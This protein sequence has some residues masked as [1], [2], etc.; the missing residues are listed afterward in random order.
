M[1]N[2]LKTLLCLPALGA[3]AAAAGLNAATITWGSTTN[4]ST[5]SDVSTAGSLLDAYHFGSG[6]VVINGVTFLGLTPSDT[7]S[8]SAGDFSFSAPNNIEVSRA[9]AGSVK[10]CQ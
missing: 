7:T 8:F 3:F 4:I 2:I 10:R 6:N 5:D 1:K 9:E